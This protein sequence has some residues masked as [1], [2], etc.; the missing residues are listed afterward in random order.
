VLITSEALSRSDDL[1]VLRALM[2]VV[3]QCSHRDVWSF[4]RTD[5]VVK[6]FL[7]ECK[8]KSEIHRRPKE[9]RLENEGVFREFSEEL[10]EKLS[11]LTDYLPSSAL[12]GEV[13]KLRAVDSFLVEVPFGKGETLW[14]KFQLSLMQGRYKEATALPIPGVQG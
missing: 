9:F 7:G 14:K 1:L 8:S 6:W 11:A 5:V 4:H 13:G 10:K 3:W 12:F 2:M